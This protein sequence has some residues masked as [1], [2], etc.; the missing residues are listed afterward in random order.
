MDYALIAYLFLA[1]GMVM[2][3]VLDGSI[4]TRILRPSPEMPRSAS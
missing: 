1:F 2:Y 4:W 3:V